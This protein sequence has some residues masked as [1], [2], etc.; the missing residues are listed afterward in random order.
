MWPRHHTTSISAQALINQK[1]D[2]LVIGAGHNGLTAAAYL[3]RSLSAATS[4]R[5]SFLASSFL[6][7]VVEEDGR[8]LLLGPDKTLN[9]SQISKFSKRDAEAYPPV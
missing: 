8:Y 5:N 3:A 2:A 6:A 1:W 4:L 9:H 7:A